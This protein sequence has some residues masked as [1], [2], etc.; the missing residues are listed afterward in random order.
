ML[1]SLLLSLREGLEAA[2]IIGIVYTTLMKTNRE[3]YL[4][5]LWQ[6]AGAA[7]GLSI[8]IGLGLNLL[9]AE[10]EGIGEMLFEGT[11]MLVAAILLT[12]MI[13]WMG[14]Q[15]RRN[16]LN[17]ETHIRRAVSQASHKAVFLLAFIAVLREGTE[18]AFFI[19]ASQF[20][21]Q[22][23]ETLAGT[24]LGLLAAGLAGWALFATT[25]K[26]NI[27]RFFQIS[28]VLL[29]FVAAGLVAHGAREFIEAG[30]LPA[31]IA[32]VW[33]ISSILSEQSIFGQISSALFGYSG[34]PSLAEVISY[35]VYF[36]G[37]GLAF[38]LSIFPK[39]HSNPNAA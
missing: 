35:L 3:D 27:R 25:R 13:F 8:V 14:R 1:T 5:N 9:G 12:W 37:L 7:I 22:G 20:G 21:T 6:G 36:L 28:N 29:M 18:L 31:G 34:N 11:S 38:S 26:L 23:L 15:A 32:H 39:R 30:W 16:Q 17:L 10:F 4:P 24:G 19:F 2:L 33:D